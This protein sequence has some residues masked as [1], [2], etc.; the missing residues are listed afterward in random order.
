MGGCPD[1]RLPPGQCGPKSPACIGCSRWCRGD[2]HPG[3]G[4]LAGV[5]G[6]T[7]PG[8]GSAGEGA[9]TGDTR[10]SVFALQT[11]LGK[12]EGRVSEV[13]EGD[14]P[15]GWGRFQDETL[16]GGADSLH[17]PRAHMAT[18]GEGFAMRACNTHSV[19]QRALCTWVPNLYP[20][21]PGSPCSGRGDAAVL[22]RSGHEPGCP[23]R[24]RGR[25]GMNLPG[26]NNTLICMVSM[27]EPLS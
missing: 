11:A 19:G 24:P 23:S 4:S 20:D 14:R 17:S 1:V 6:D 25:L 8:A 13:L 18:G 16:I 27:S 2:T 10:V 15:P 3:A 12:Q 7:H 5:G 26:V 9:L 21:C 22:A